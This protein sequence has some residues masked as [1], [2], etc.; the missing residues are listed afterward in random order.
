MSKMTKFHVNKITK[1]HISKMTKFRVIKK[2]SDFV[3][4]PFL[5]SWNDT[6]GEIGKIGEM[7]KSSKFCKMKIKVGEISFGCEIKI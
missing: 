3:I 1:F 5:S 2:G 4:K 6:M 7:P